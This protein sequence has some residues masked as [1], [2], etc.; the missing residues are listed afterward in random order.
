MP[1]VAILIATALAAG[2]LHAFAPD[3]LAAVGVFVSRRPSWRRA[4]SLGAR[5]GIG[6]S[7]SIALVGGI[8]VLSGIRLPARFAPAAERVVGL[9]L[10]AIGLAAIWR[11]RRLHG[12]AHAHDGATHWHVHSHETSA[13]HDHSHGAL[14]GIGMLHGLAGT[15]ALVVAMPAVAG[16]RARSLIFLVAFGLGTI[17]AMACFGATAG[18]AL[19]LATHRRAPLHRAA[20]A[21]A[22]LASAA[23]G[24]WWVASG[25]V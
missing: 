6:H 11:A 12:H 21:G 3:H 15:G 9:T 1:S 8:V 20:M 17:A 23:V 4:A 10:I 13:G 14:L 18:H 24:V 22:G 5:W 2:A 25:G 7:L 19:T 16:S